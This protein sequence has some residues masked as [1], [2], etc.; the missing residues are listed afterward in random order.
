MAS[1]SSTTTSGF[2]ALPADSGKIRRM[3]MT[4]S[5]SRGRDGR[6]G[7]AEG[8]ITAPPPGGLLV[9]AVVDVQDR[10]LAV[11]LVE[12]SVLQG[13][14]DPAPGAAGAGVDLGVHRGRVAAE[15]EVVGGAGRLP[16]HRAA[17]DGDEGRGDLVH[18]HLAVVEVG[19]VARQLGGRAARVQAVDRRGLVDGD[20]V[21]ATGGGAAGPRAAVGPE[22]V[23]DGTD[24]DGEGEAAGDDGGLLLDRA[25]LLPFFRGRVTG[26]AGGG[27]AR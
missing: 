19:E 2:V 25:H 5:R 14:L 13:D 10:V 6:M 26:A 24:G 3:V 16:T 7:P 17:V 11:V 21:V 23:G 18:E 22:R 27:G 20:G 15:L 4:L 1:A 12:R 9:A 8:R